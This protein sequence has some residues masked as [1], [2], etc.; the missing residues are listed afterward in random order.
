[1]RKLP[2]SV[3]PKG[4]PRYGGRVKGQPNKAFYSLKMLLDRM[5]PEPQLEKLWN[6][7]LHHRNPFIAYRTFELAL[8]YRFGRPGPLNDEEVAL[9][10][11]VDLSGFPMRHVPLVQ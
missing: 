8:Q 7:H 5:L 2:H 3:F 9:M 4:H 1:M 6:K 10:N 11:Q